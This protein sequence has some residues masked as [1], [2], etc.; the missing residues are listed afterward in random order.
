MHLAR[1]LDV[2]GEPLGYRKVAAIKLLFN[3][4]QEKAFTVLPDRFTFKEAKLAYDKM[5]QATSLFL[6]KCIAIGIL[7][8]IKHGLYEKV[9]ATE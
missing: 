5:D 7:Q 6:K 3:V 4:D 2:D 8:K 9:K 1:I